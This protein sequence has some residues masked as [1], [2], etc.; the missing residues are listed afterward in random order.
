[1][2]WHRLNLDTRTWVTAFVG[3]LFPIGLLLGWPPFYAELAYDYIPVRSDLILD[4]SLVALFLVMPGLLTVIAKRRAF[5]WGLVPL[6]MASPYF[7]YMSKSEEWSAE[8]VVTALLEM[9]V[10]WIVSSGVGL[11]IRRLIRRNALKKATLATSP[12]VDADAWPP[13]PEP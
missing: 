1:M 11:V 7:M 8:T 2:N 13:A 6:L 4:A 10:G 3:T 5:F 9:L 12:D